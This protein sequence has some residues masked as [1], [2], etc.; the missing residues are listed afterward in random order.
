MADKKLYP[1]PV[2]TTENGTKIFVTMDFKAKMDEEEIPVEDFWKLKV[3][4][5]KVEPKKI[6]LDVGEKSAPIFSI[7]FGWCPSHVRGFLMMG[8]LA[9]PYIFM[10]LQCLFMGLEKLSDAKRA[11]FIKL[12]KLL[13]DDFFGK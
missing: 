6:V 10:C 4:V 13:L 9:D 11:L 8:L 1:D 5:I 2:H 7:P 3:E 12:I